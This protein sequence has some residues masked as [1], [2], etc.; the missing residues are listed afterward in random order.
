[1]MSV[2]S[3]IVP[4]TWL[5]IVPVIAAMLEQHHPV[6]GNLH[7]YTV[8]FSIVA[9]GPPPTKFLLLFCVMFPCISG[10]KEE[11]SAMCSE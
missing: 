2:T 8:I 4:G 3:V 10:L 7:L 6:A 1:M 9:V 11:H 5:A